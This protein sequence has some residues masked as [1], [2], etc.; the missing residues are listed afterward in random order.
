LRFGTALALATTA[1]IVLPLTPAH[2]DREK[3]PSSSCTIVGTPGPDVLRGTKHDDFI[4]G[5]G[6]DDKILGRGGDD[7][8]QGGGGDDLLI[9]GPGNDVLGGGRGNDTLNGLDDAT[10][11]D[12]MRCGRGKDQVKADVPDIVRR[13]CEKVEQD[14]APTDLGLAPA[15]VAENQPG[16]TA[17]GTLSATDPDPGD[18]HTFT[19]VAGPGSAD[20]GSFTIVGATLRTAGPLDFETTPSQS[21]RVRATDSGGLS[22]EKALTVTVVDVDDPPA[23]A[24]DAKTVAEDAAPTAIDVLA[25]DTDPDGGPKLVAS[26]T[27][28]AHGTVVITGGGSGVTYEPD[29]DYCNTP[30]P[31]DTFTYTLNGGDVGSVD[32]TVTCVDD[33]AVAVD[34]ATT[35]AEDAPATV[36]DVLANDTDVEG[37]PF[38][39]TAVGAAAHGT[40]SST[41]SNVTYTPAANYCGPDSFTYTITGGDSATVSVTVTCTNDAPVATDD[42][43]STTED[44]PLVFPA[45]DLLG[46]DTDPDAGDTLSVSSVSNPTGGTVSLATGTVTFTPT[47]NLC[48]PAA[49]GF[50]YVVSDGTLSDTGHVTVDVTCVNDPAVAVDDTRT[51]TEDATTGFLVLTNDS[52]PEGD[53]FSIIAV[54]DP[55]HGSVTFNA[56]SV[57]YTPD[58]DYCGPDSFDYTITGGD[59]ATVSVDVTCV[60]DAPVVDLDTTAGGSGSTA[61]FSETSPHTGNGVL[62]APDAAVTDVDDANL[63]SLTVVLTNRPDGDALESLSATIPPGSGIA[64]GTYVPATGTLSFTGTASK[65]SY[66]AVVASI[67]YDNTKAVPSTTDRIITVVV[68]DGDLASATATATVH[69][70]P[71]NLPPVNTVPG[72]QTIDEDTVLTFGAGK[73][74][75]VTDG[76]HGSL[77]VAVTVTHG[78]FTLSGTAGLTVTGNGTASVTLSGTLANLNA[79]LSG[80]TY[81]PAADYNGPALLTITSTDALSAADTDTVAI[82]VTSVNDAPSATGHTVTTS[83]GIGLTISASDSGDL[84]EGATDPDDPIGDLTVQLVPGSVSPATATVTLLSGADGSFYVEPPGGLSG[85]GAVTFAFQVCDDNAGDPQQCSAQQTQTVNVSGPD[86]WFVDD[87]DAAGCAAACTGS[88]TKPLVGLGALPAGRGTGDRVFLFSGSYGAGHTFPAS[89]VLVGQG[90]T[91]S[92]DALLGVTVPANGTLDSRPSLGGTRPALAGTVTLATDAALRGV[93]ISTG[94]ATGLTDPAGATNGVAVAETSV[95]TTTGTA[96]L[97]DGIGGTIVVDSVGHSGGS[98]AGIAVQ[99]N[100]AALA[101]SNVT[102]SSGSAPAFSVTGATG[103][104]ATTGTNTLTTTTGTALRVS[105]G[106]EIG[107]PGLTF[108]SVSSNGAANGIVLSNTG[109]SGGLTVTGNGGACAAVADACSGGTIQSSTGDGISLTSTQH[110]SLTRVK[111]VDNLGNGVRGA[112]VTDFQ[113]ADS[114]VDNNGD[115]AATDEAGL[116]LT[117]LAGTAGIVRTPVAHSPEDNA[118]IVNTSGTLSQL[119]VTDSIFRDTDTVSPGNNG[120]LLQADG[121]SINADVLGSSF[122]RNRANGLQAVTN[123][124]GTMTVE[125]NDSG[126]AA[127]VFDDNNIGVNLAHNSSGSFTYDV[128]NTTVDGL[129]VPAGTGGSASPINVNLAAAATSTMT[130]TLLGNTLTNSN[131]TTGPG[132]RITSNGTATL[133]TLVTGN[134]VSQVANRGIEIIARDGSSR[135][136]AT[137]TN[138]VVNLNHALAGDAIRLDA[139][140]VSTDTTTVCADMFGNTATTSA[141]GLFGIRVRQRFA[142]T[143]FLLEGYAGSA[144]DDAAVQAFLAGQNNAATTSADHAGAGFTSGN[145]P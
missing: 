11:R 25:N 125:V 13:T 2:A 27:Q 70:V 72:A 23:A 142:G 83:S 91:G 37:D 92:F 131:S 34:D 87:T 126:T 63:E 113:I 97:L 8:L 3:G 145:C 105:G 98:G 132:I 77:D 41:A 16:G 129:N 6:G 127:S 26:L 43:K 116:H 108:R 118:R 19:L 88:R 67:R 119:N 46:N 60:N 64:G 17:V 93:A 94:A 31:F 95:A 18:A 90:A 42:T 39:V 38:S 122:L 61:T 22:V 117:N 144:T 138:N 123:L 65:A 104:V 57:A 121:G 102:I 111:V 128:R 15:S 68:D 56:T 44:L 4:C 114:V 101:F 143:H 32:V 35:V 133:T 30:P 100:A 96:V 137:V 21:V 51:A 84:K 71:L 79:A 48:G 74:I 120:L 12:R 103:T 24:D 109:P 135:I 40:T 85:A 36:I 139:G 29:A 140:A 124:T 28:P 58:A 47:A 115:D 20:N 10:A 89:E 134:N 80:A 62:V 82:T 49:G 53:P 59:T 78:T 66:A 55:P 45:T 141:V 106:T 73:V 112:S 7:V 50:D 130:G 86:R 107:G 52:D 136:N 5:L 75:S 99:A 81:T 1:W 76:D 14:D 33:P 110:V 9:G 54:T 69:V